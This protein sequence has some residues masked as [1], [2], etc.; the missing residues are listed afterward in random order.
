[1]ALITGTPVGNLIVSEDIYLEGAPNIY[2][3]DYN[4]NPMKNPDASGYYWG[5]SGTTTYP[6]YE[7]GCPMDVS[8]TEGL[9]TNDVMCDNVG[10][11]DT[12]QQRNYLEL[13]FTIKSF[14]PLPILRHV[15][16]ASAVSE[17]APVEEFGFGKINNNQ[18]WMVYCPKVYDEDVGD[19]IVIHLHKAKFVDA[20]TISMPFGASWQITGLKLRAYADTSKPAA[21]QFGVFMRSDASAVT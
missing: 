8:L 9:T 20:W 7:L 17:I 11:K 19:Y 4:A 16:S 12:V 10:V 3:Q 13:A 21:Q 5:V 2:I 15:L 6:V 1:M 18:K 14:F